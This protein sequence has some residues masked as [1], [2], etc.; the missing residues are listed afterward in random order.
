MKGGSIEHHKNLGGD[1]SVVE[2]EPWTGRDHSSVIAGCTS[3]QTAHGI[4][5]HLRNA[6][7]GVGWSKSE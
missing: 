2:Y 3:T 6:M 5:K 7:L 4:G 1:S